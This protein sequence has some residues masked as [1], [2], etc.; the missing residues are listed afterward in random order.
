MDHVCQSGEESKRVCITHAIFRPPNQR[1]IKSI[2]G[3][4]LKITEL[5]MSLQ[6]PS[7][8]PKT[9]YLLQH[10][11]ITSAYYIPQIIHT[12]AH[13][14]WICKIHFHSVQVVQNFV[15]VA[16]AGNHFWSHCTKV[17]FHRLKSY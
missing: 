4:H 7:L 16:G 17:A 10:H 2:T 9:E 3:Y 11:E 15:A 1:G 13:W 8:H 6:K 14:V 5:P 12:H